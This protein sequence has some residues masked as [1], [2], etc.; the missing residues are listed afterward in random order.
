MDMIEP[1]TPLPAAHPSDE[2]LALLARRRSTP[3][4]LLHEP[5]PDASQLDVI[6]RIAARVPDHRKLVP[7]RFVVF[8][9][10]ARGAFGDVLTKAA[11]ARDPDL[12]ERKAG[13]DAALFVQAPVTVAV[14]SSVDREHKTPEW[15]QV[16]TAGAVCQNLLIAA[17]AYGFAGQ[18]LTG[19][20][21]YDAT[22]RES[23]A[24]E[25]NERIAGF[26]HLGTAAEQP[27]E[28][29]RPDMDAIV[30]RWEG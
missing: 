5:G 4:Q 15:E 22:V 18:W 3:L 7:F 29:D 17:S 8:E 19:S 24:L 16:L 2:T 13:K 28:R 6:L 10:T 9:G 14:V 27:L 20:A 25:P 11:L 12:S 26:L 23:L 21:A 1:G 30:T